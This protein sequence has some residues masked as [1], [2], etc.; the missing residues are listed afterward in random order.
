[1]A[2]QNKPNTFTGILK[3]VRGT[4]DKK[5]PSTNKQGLVGTGNSTE[6]IQQNYLDFQ[7]NRIA[8]D[9]Y[10]RTV[11]Y[12][13][14]RI[15][16]YQDYRA[17]DHSPEVAQ[18]L[19]IMRDECLVPNEYGEILQVYS[20][21][22]RIKT[23]LKDLF[24]N[25]LNVNYLL[26]L[27]IRDL[28]MYGDYFVYLHVNKDHGVTNLQSLPQEEIFREEGHND[29]IDSV[30][31]RWEA[32]NMYFEEWQIAH[33]RLLESTK[34]L[35]Y[36]RSVL[37]PARKLWKQLQLAEDALL[38]YR[39]TRAPDRRIFYIEV[40]SLDPQ[41]V[42][43]Y[44]QNMQKALKKQP[45]VNQSNGNINFKFDPLNVTE[46]YFIPIRGDHHSKIDTLPGASNLGDIQDINYLQD[47]LFASL[48]VPKP[49]LNFSENIPGG[50]TLSQSDIR[51]ARTINR[52]QEVVLME[53]RH[54]AKVH[55]FAK[56]FTT[57]YENFVLKL[58]NPS[59][60]LELMK[61]EI[62]KARL[63]VAK[64]WHNPQANSFASWT[65]VMEYIFGFSKQDIK[66]MLKQKKIEK[67]L[68]AEIEAATET[69][70][71]T[72]LFKDL[73][74]KYKIPGAVAGGDQEGGGGEDK[75]G[76]FSASSALK[77][78]DL[79]GTQMGGDDT[80]GGG[81]SAPSGGGGN[82]MSGEAPEEPLNEGRRLNS[83]KEQRY[84]SLID[85]LLEDDIKPAKK[86]EIFVEE[87]LKLERTRRMFDSMQKKLNGIDSDVMDKN[88]IQETVMTSFEDNPLFGNYNK[89]T[90]KLTD[91]IKE[92]EDTHMNLSPQE[93]ALTETVIPEID[94]IV[95]EDASEDDIIED[96]E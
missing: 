48:K 87:T 76:G 85:E 30:R 66:K 60:Q 13:T 12:D 84:N 45:V 72:G 65:W 52:F 90:K 21:N 7:V 91:M 50:A 95:V 57:E 20:D 31:F 28:L 5:E 15:S 36:G 88:I 49:Y 42:K 11:Y 80:G 64:E 17:M 10:R 94:D 9:L 16:A 24:V 2:D 63:E 3:M 82:D 44:M 23:E 47:K 67:K 59:T 70:K 14:D 35:P 32:N 53:L 89:L 83:L 37:D 69:Y 25:R 46:D 27:W 68:F 75:D 29:Q 93:I 81:F 74:R 6:Q 58:N 43:G 92:M 96:K 33:F 56:G 51:F 78:E 77:P 22:E 71:D 38:V 4:P 61:L 18:A 62:M 73:D 79:M 41:D 26:S 19:D 86:K 54:I 39:V 1:M 34:R 8:N 40:G 55:L